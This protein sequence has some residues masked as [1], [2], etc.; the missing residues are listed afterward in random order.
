MNESEGCSASFCVSLP[1][2]EVGLHRHAACLP[3]SC[4]M[5]KSALA[6]KNS[7][8][9][10]VN[11]VIGPLGVLWDETSAMC[12]SE[13]H[14]WHG[15]Q[16]CCG[17]RHTGFLAVWTLM[18]PQTCVSPAAAVLEVDPGRWRLDSGAWLLRTELKGPG[19]CTACSQACRLA[20]GLIALGPLQEAG[21]GFPLDAVPPQDSSREQ[22]GVAA[23]KLCLISL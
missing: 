17:P 7:K 13:R 14:A 1:V 22:Q 8:C 20:T 10:M 21:R 9:S 19:S 23:G 6:Q 15:K 4:V 5:A 11:P 12:T 16:A 18:A 3:Q 2:G